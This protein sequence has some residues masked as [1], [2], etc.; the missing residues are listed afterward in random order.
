MP[1]LILFNRRWHVG[2]DDLFF[3]ALY[4][5]VVHSI[6]LLGAAVVYHQTR[7]NPPGTCTNPNGLE[8]Y[9]VMSVV[10]LVM[11]LVAETCI[12]YLSLQGT[13]ADPRPRRHINKPI[14]CHSGLMLLELATQVYGLHL[15]L[16]SDPL[17]CTPASHIGFLIHSL[18]YLST[19]A[20]TVY[21]IAVLLLYLRSTP[22]NVDSI[23]R[24]ALWRTRLSFLFVSHSRS[25][26]VD[27]GSG[28]DEPDVLSDVA[29]IF[30]EF[31]EDVETV[32]SD[33][34]VGV[35]LL[36]RKQQA[37]RALMSG[38]KWP[39]EQLGARVSG[40]EEHAMG[41][42]RVSL[43]VQES[44]VNRSSSEHTSPRISV[45]LPAPTALDIPRYEDIQD[46][47]YFYQYAESI[48]G[49][50]LFM[51][52]NFTRGVYHL[53][54]PWSRA[55]PDTAIAA[56]RTVTATSCIPCLPSSP[57]L[58]DQLPHA[59]L[60]Y[61]SL[62]GGLFRTPFA[63]CFDHPRQTIV[64]AVRGTLSTADVLVDLHCDLEE[65]TVPGLAG[66]VKAYTH[67]GM[68]RTARNLKDELEASGT[69]RRLLLEENSRY[70]GYGLVCCGHSLGGG[71]AALLAFLL[72]TTS[73]PTARAIAYS[74]PGC[75]IT[76]EAN[77]YFA[78]FC[79]S[80]VLGSDIVPRL[81]RNTV[82]KLKQQVNDLI[83]TCNEHKVRVLG[84]FLLG[85]CFGAPWYERRAGQDGGLDG[86]QVNVMDGA[87]RDVEIG[88]HRSRRKRSW[89]DEYPTTYL[90][91]RVLYFCKER[92][93]GSVDSYST[94]PSSSD[95]V[96]LL[97]RPA[98]D[99]FDNDSEPE[100]TTRRSFFSKCFRKRPR[101]QARRRRDT[102]RPVWASPEE[103]QEIE[104]SISMAAD[105]MP[106]NLS[107]VLMRI[108]EAGR[109]G[110]VPLPAVGY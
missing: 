15:I 62:Q 43:A 53:C 50:P 45:T 81:N 102:Y 13:V 49:L 85:E 104:I 6:W 18:I 68:F 30:A 34:L 14:Y 87:W 89:N 71:V 55:P 3:P 37:A 73:Y 24:T 64:I 109:S 29:R 101:S 94:L 25:G 75:M 61:L 16:G 39:S 58:S 60:I 83:D 90:P 79:T 20:V 44:L 52:T 59:D 28:G 46:I 105:H 22:L 56:I 32:P 31:L 11:E 27:G 82:E 106:N 97:S 74:P 77:A 17:I 95:S 92:I 4:G 42:R 72:R 63:I 107:T 2:S 36:R 88:E 19:A 69:L 66:D 57:T 7:N 78:T 100:Y 80:V 54:C 8:T 96:A 91:G 10:T 35:V 70:K 48:Y 12:A 84:S 110:V 93:P 33:I 76:H 108:D 67:A 51:F 41:T 26:T 40:S 38:K 1:S 99:D 47:T 5:F 65:I 21:L 23:D 86:P 9:L 103:F 98:S